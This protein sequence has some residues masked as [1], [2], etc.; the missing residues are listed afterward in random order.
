MV[1][2]ATLARVL[3]LLALTGTAS[4]LRVQQNP[5]EALGKTISK[6]VTNDVKESIKS[7][8]LDKCMEC[9][10]KLSMCFSLDPCRKTLN[11]ALRTKGN[12][13]K[14]NCH[15]E[16]GREGFEAV[17]PTGT[18]LYQNCGNCKA[19]I[20]QIK[21]NPEQEVVVGCARCVVHSHDCNENQK[22][23][24]VKECLDKEKRTAGIEECTGGVT[25][26]DDKCKAVNPIEKAE[27]DQARKA[28]EV[29][30]CRDKCNGTPYLETY[31]Q[32]NMRTKGDLKMAMADDHYADGLLIKNRQDLPIVQQIGVLM[33]PPR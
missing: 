22:C 29:L 2:T 12:A 15:V 13:T 9:A 30:D 18:A 19:T 1:K 32:I 31:E 21:V 25:T 10:P 20:E 26:K 27:C 5:F 23:K 7:A 16:A 3:G 33:Q 28:L 4:A 6:A 24:E 11:C 8:G 14:E 17:E